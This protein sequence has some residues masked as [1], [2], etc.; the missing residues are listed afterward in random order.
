MC[1]HP[2]LPFWCWLWHDIGLTNVWEDILIKWIGPGMWQRPIELIE[3]ASKIHIII[4]PC[5]SY[6]LHLW[7]QYSP[8]SDFHYVRDFKHVHKMLLLIS[9]GAKSL[10]FVHITLLDIIGDNYNCTN[11]YSN[12]YIIIR[13]V[14]F[15]LTPHS[16]DLS[17]NPLIVHIR[18][19]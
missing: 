15:H 3:H 12:W 17:D 5:F 4:P 19:H 16:H 11:G 13:R 18:E 9:D 10:F 2:H 14:I 8:T 7:N 6:T 1:T